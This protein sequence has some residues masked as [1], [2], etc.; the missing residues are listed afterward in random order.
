MAVQ[1]LCFDLLMTVSLLCLAV[2]ALHDN[3]FGEA[4][5]A[6]TES[7]KSEDILKNGKVQMQVTAEKQGHQVDSCANRIADEEEASDICGEDRGLSKLDAE[8]KMTSSSYEQCEA[9]QPLRCQEEKAEYLGKNPAPEGHG[10]ENLEQISDQ[11]KDAEFSGN[12]IQRSMQGLEDMLGQVEKSGVKVFEKLGVVMDQVGLSRQHMMKSLDSLMDQVSASSSK[13]MEEIDH[14]IDTVAHSK[15]IEEIRAFPREIRESFVLSVRN[16]SYVAAGIMVAITT[17]ILVAGAVYFSWCHQDAWPHHTVSLESLT[18]YKDKDHVYSKDNNGVICKDQDGVNYK[19]NNVVSCKDKDVVNSK[20]KDV[21]NSKD[22]DDVS[23][24]GKDDV[25]C[26][27]KDDVS[28]EDKDDVSSEDKDDVHSKDKDDVKS[29]DKDDVKSKDKDNA[30]TQDCMNSKAAVKRSFS[31]QGLKSISSHHTT[32]DVGFNEHPDDQNTNSTGDDSCQR[33][34]DSFGITGL[35][36]KCQHKGMPSQDEF[37]NSRTSKDKHNKGMPVTDEDQRSMPFTDQHQSA[38]A[39][40]PLL[41]QDK[42]HASTFVDVLCTFE[43]SSDANFGCIKSE[44][45]QLRSSVSGLDSGDA[46]QDTQ[47]DTVPLNISSTEGLRNI[48]HSTEVTGKSLEK[49]DS[50]NKFLQSTVSAGKAENCGILREGTII[51]QESVSIEN[52][53]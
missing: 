36:G 19:D 20:D 39:H 17:A 31:A 41:S 49:G 18:D 46:G 22:K 34:S 14:V 15:V 40:E 16:R 33:P 6:A 52:R 45:R 48:S 32:A 26:K 27:G 21:V 9:E 8:E 5:Q 37:R 10:V 43:S 23:C 53:E 3:T 30:N 2:H 12:I 29:I 42:S 44:D 4:H 11:V 25:S 24:K 50:K 1:H 47:S 7:Y 38:S 51:H 35:D 28:S 13:M